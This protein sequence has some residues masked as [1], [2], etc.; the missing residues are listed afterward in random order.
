MSGTVENHDGDI[1]AAKRELIKKGLD[2]GEL[3]RDE[4]AEQ[5]PIDH[6]SDVEL[7][8]LKFTFKSL[9]ITVVES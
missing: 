4:I 1:Q 8:V 5:L 3:T 6:M 7:D 9:G 2:Q